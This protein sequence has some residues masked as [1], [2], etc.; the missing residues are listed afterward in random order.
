[1]SKEFDTSWFDLKNYEAFKTMPIS[2]WIWQLMKRHDYMDAVRVSNPDRED[3]AGFLLSLATT[4]KSGVI[5]NIPQMPPESLAFKA[6]CGEHTFSTTSVDSLTSKGLWYLA[7]HEKLKHVWDACQ[8]VDE[9]LFSDDVPFDDDLSTVACTP[10]E[11]DPKTVLSSKI[12]STPI[13]F[14]IRESMTPGAGVYIHTSAHLVVDLSA[15]DE[16]IK[17]DFSHWLKH[18]RQEIQYQNK[19]KL[20]SQTDF[21][22]WIEYSVIPYMDL[23]FIAKIEG[24]KITQNKLARLIFP[25]EYEVDVVERVRKVTKPTAEWLTTNEI[26]IALITQYSYEKRME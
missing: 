25:N 14:H 2:G 26:F 1:M 13:D 3:T 10:V 7:T 11:D 21:N 19:R 20:F 6:N 5:P 9:F 24:K 18:F 8:H 23:I 4:L 17:M 22:Y 12:A 16:Q 15:T